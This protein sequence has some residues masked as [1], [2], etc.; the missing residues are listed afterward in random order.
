MKKYEYFEATADI[1]FKAYGK[2]LNEAFEN[3]GTAMF[4]I[5]TD[6]E[7]VEPKNEISF[8]I[9]RAHRRPPHL[10][11]FHHV[12]TLDNTRVHLSIITLFCFLLFVF[13]KHGF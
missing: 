7:D 5:I 8:E 1:G 2:T 9:H 11:I 13:S 4:N 10:T 3:A 6:T 12:S